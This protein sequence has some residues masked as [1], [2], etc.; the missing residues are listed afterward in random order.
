M[1]AKQGWGWAEGT[2][3][4]KITPVP[5][6]HCTV[7]FCLDICIQLS[8]YSFVMYTI[9]LESTSFVIMYVKNHAPCS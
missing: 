7:Y 3:F 4:F 2:S 5:P 8:L 9:Q 6:F 1:L